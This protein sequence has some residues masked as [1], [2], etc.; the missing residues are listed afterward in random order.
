MLELP[1]GHDTHDEGTIMTAQKWARLER[2][3][4]TIGTICG[5]DWHNWNNFCCTVFEGTMGTITVFVTPQVQIF[6]HILTFF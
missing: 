5:P 3:V 6:A 4:G 1:K 2:Y